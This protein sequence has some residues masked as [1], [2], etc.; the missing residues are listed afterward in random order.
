MIIQETK[1]KGKLC[2]SVHPLDFLSVSE[3]NYNWRS[4]HALD[5]DYRSGN[6]EYMLDET[7]IV[8]YL[9]GE[10]EEA[11]L[12]RFPDNVKWND[13]K[14]RML[15]F[16]GPHDNLLMA[17]RQYPMFSR[18]AL[19]IVFSAYYQSMKLNRGYSSWV[20]DYVNKWPSSLGYEIDLD[21]KYI[22]IQRKLYY[23]F[24]LIISNGHHLFYN[25]LLHS[26]Y[27]TPYYCWKERYESYDVSEL[28]MRIGR[29]A[30][31]P[32]CGKEYITDSSTMVCDNCWF[33]EEEKE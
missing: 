27:Y 15:L 22:C 4:C 21:H 32:C 2:L 25:D 17:G 3:N 5:G 16:C 28:R 29:S 18:P 31:C 7:T 1:V 13:K 12:Q 14:W 30:I 20:N 19:D 8:C 6:L 11:Y 9:K 10:N 24:D 23:M 26:S 33:D